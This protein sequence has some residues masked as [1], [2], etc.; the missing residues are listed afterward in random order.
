MSKKKKKRHVRCPCCRSERYKSEMKMAIAALAA[1][2]R[3]LYEYYAMYQKDHFLSFVKSHFIW[4]CDVCIRSEKAILT[5]PKLQNYRTTPYYAYFDTTRTCRSCNTKFVFSKEEKVFWFE[6]LKFWI[7][8]KPVNCLDCRKTIRQLKLENATLSEILKK[9]KAIITS[10]ELVMV[11]DI[12]AK[13]QKE[14]RVKYY[15]SILRKRGM[16]K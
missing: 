12:Y 8:A 16:L 10:V 6:E 5:K 13:W 15:Q 7:E 2:E 4:A 11:I 3:G 14:D 9:D 1:F